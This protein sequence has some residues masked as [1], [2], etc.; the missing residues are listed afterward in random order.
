MVGGGV[1]VNVGVRLRVFMKFLV[2][3]GSCWLTVRGVVLVL[4]KKHK[5]FFSVCVF[6]F[7]EWFATCFEVGC[8]IGLDGFAGFFCEFGSL[9]G[10]PDFD[11]F[12]V[13]GVFE[14]LLE[15]FAL[16]VRGEGV[17]PL[18]CELGFVFHVFLI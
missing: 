3:W 13:E 4:L 1:G 9:F 2:L 15:G 7:Y 16:L 12:G 11:P 17:V 18:E 8:G 10:F 6:S 5:Q 14:E